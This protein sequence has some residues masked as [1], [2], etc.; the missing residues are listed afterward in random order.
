MISSATVDDGFDL[1]P[2]PSSASVLGAAAAVGPETTRTAPSASL[3][4]THC[5][6]VLLTGDLAVKWKKSLDLGFVD[7]RTAAAREHACRREVELNRRFAPDVYRD[8]LAVTDGAGRVREWLVL[9]NQMPAD[10]RLSTLVTGGRLVDDA[11]RAVAHILAA[12]HAGARRSAQIEANGTPA[13]LLAR[14]MSNIGA[15]AVV[16]Q[17]VSPDRVELLARLVRAYIAGCHPLLQARLAAGRVRDGHGDLLAD[18]IFCLDDGPR[19]LDCLE[20]DD[21]LRAVDGVDDAAVLAMDL[22]RLGAPELAREFMNRYVEFSADPC[23]PSL[24]HHYIAYRAVMRAKIAAIRAEQGDPDAAAQVRLLVDIGLRHLRSAQPV[25]ILVGGLPGT[26]KTTVASHLADSLGGVLLRSDRIRK[27]GAGLDPNGSHRV[28]AD[29]YTAERTGATYRQ[30]VERA[31]LLLGRGESVILDA[32]WSS[33]QH[34]LEVRE[35]AATGFATVRELQCVA[36]TAV[37][38]RRL[39]DRRAAGVDPSD[40]TPEIAH[41]L[42]TTFDPWPEATVIDTDRELT[43]STRAVDHALQLD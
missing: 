35:L 37:A 7:W 10:R 38:D 20:F 30:M 16:D 29:L 34:R 27:E 18:D 40:A 19:I 5:A 8:V 3:R 12:H 33:A 39:R 25:L 42:A 24:I 21:D 26:G 43:S 32:T 6:W 31:Q 15:L 11:L 41:S 13:A 4:E 36:P 14:W 9:M 2:D 28:A 1:A 23:P 22:E 17:L